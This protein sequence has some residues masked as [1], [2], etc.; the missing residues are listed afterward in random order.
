MEDHGLDKEEA[1]RVKEIKDEHGLDIDEA[2]ELKD[3]L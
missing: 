1:E 2:L 3:D